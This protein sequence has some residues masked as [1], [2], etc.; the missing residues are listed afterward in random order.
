MPDIR[1]PRQSISSLLRRL[2]L[3]FAVEAAATPVA[4][5]D[6]RRAHANKAAGYA[7]ASLRQLGYTVR[8]VG[9][10][11]RS[12]NNGASS[13]VAHPSTASSSKETAGAA[14]EATLEQGKPTPAPPLVVD[15]WGTPGARAEKVW[16][17]LLDAYQLGGASAALV[18]AA[19]EYARTAYRITV[20]EDVTFDRVLARVST[21]KGRLYELGEGGFMVL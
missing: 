20:G 2:S 11:W 15:R 17:A 14:S 7:L 13:S 9:G 12:D 3:A 8:E 19:R 10:R 4:C 6:A 1:V 5:A 18:D 21:E 16:L